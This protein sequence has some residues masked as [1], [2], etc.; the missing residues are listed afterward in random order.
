MIDN[1]YLYREHIYN[2]ELHQQQLTFLKTGRPS[3]LTIS[4][5]QNPLYYPAKLQLRWE[6]QI[7]S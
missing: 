2:S 4:P 1:S 6:Y 7:I 3:F 5:L